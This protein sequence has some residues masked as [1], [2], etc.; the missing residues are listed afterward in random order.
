MVGQG[1][2]WNS[3]VGP[4][5]YSRNII[6]LASPAASEKNKE[7]R[8]SSNIRL[9]SFS[10]ATTK[11]NEAFLYQVAQSWNHSVAF[12]LTPISIHNCESRI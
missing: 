4:I 12:L 11:G 1:H 2:T 6:Q 5:S 9:S 10:T 7:P 3:K 8:T